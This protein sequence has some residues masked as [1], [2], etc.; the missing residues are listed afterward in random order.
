MGAPGLNQ[1]STEYAVSICAMDSSGPFNLELR[2]KLTDI[3]ER[4]GVDYRVDIYPHYSSD[5][6]AALRAGYDIKAAL[7]GPGV[8]ASHAYERTHMDSI[9]N[10]FK[11]L[12][13]YLKQK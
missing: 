9:I 4:E 8:F 10:T 5:A 3:A 12:I 13:E 11:L 7:I 2:K 1:N 6:L